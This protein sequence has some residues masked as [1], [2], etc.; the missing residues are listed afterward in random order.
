MKF[1]EEVKFFDKDNIDD[2][3]L[4]KVKPITS[5]PEFNYEKMESISSAAA[6]LCTWAVNVLDYNK[7][8]KKVKPL[9]DTADEAASEVRTAEAKLKVV[10]DAVA[11]I[12]AK[13]AE[14][15]AK[16][17]EAIATKERVEAEAKA[18]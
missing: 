16:L 4:E 15:Q 18:F 14:L 3:K 6:N 1:I 5:K 11:D 17:D 13:V 8:Y 12:N 2:W 10:K 9:M 7:I